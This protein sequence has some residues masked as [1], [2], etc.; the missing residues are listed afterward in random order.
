M[1]HNRRN[2]QN[3]NN[4]GGKPVTSINE[5]CEEDYI[6]MKNELMEFEE[7]IQFRIDDL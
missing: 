7:I 3:N 4:S 6:F 1:V 2:S 5:I